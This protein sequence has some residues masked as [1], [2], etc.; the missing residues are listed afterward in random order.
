MSCVALAFNSSDSV[1]LSGDIRLFVITQCFLYDRRYILMVFNDKNCNQIFYYFL[2]L[3]A[4]CT[5]YYSAIF[6]VSD[7][8]VW[9]GFFWL[10]IENCSKSNLHKRCMNLMTSTDVFKIYSSS[11]LIC[12]VC[13]KHQQKL[14]ETYSLQQL[15]PSMLQYIVTSQLFVSRTFELWMMSEQITD[16]NISD[17]FK[18]TDFF[19]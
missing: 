12:I 8:H 16:T 15:V 5:N 10:C 18:T 9:K 11:A 7:L 3:V 19:K 6:T 2:Q 13:F 14:F 17:F 1:N 4:R